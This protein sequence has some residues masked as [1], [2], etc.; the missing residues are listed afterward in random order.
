MELDKNTIR[1][2]SGV[3][4]LLFIIYIGINHLEGI[5]GILQYVYEL[6]F[7]FILGGC[8][9]FVLNIPMTFFNKNL[10]KVKS[11]GIGKLICKGDR[12]IS[13]ILSC[14][15]V[16]GIVALALYIIIPSIIDTFKILP[17]T[18][19]SSSV[20]FKQWIENN[21]WISSNIA[22]F[23]NSMQVSWD[24]IFNSAVNYI[25]S[26]VINGASSMMTVTIGMA[27]TFASGI[28]DFVL[29]FVFA[30]YILLQKETLGKQCKKILY[31]FLNKEHADLILEVAE[32]T[33]KTF[34]NFVSGQCFESAILGIMFF[35]TMTI[36]KVPY[37][38]VGSVFIAFTA[39]VPIIG[40]IIGF[41]FVEF[42]IVM[43]DPTKALLFLIVY[44][45]IKQI[46]DN[47]IYPR[48]VGN[49]V[50]LPSI[51]VLFVITVG[52]KLMG[53]AGM[54]IFIPLCSV[55]YVL[56]REEVYKKLKKKEIDI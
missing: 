17:Q 13:L 15:M 8:I 21:S 23:I 51:W 27:A 18:F 55:A 53:I 32:L 26:T 33:S 35:L 54:I 49:S 3:I 12:A 38:L 6:V 1:K 31:A 4:I 9:A 2:I 25:K 56:F 47:F 48:I 34:S 19:Q 24:S 43:A 7:P 20:T 46:E 36:L 42:L 10:S 30:I 29:G 14:I 22:N 16:I 52:G 45:I 44:I 40:S 5:V 50:G 11:K 28:F 41:V 37:A 39:I